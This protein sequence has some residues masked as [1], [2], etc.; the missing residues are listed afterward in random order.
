MESFWF[1]YG[2]NYCNSQDDLCRIIGKFGKIVLLFF[3]LHEAH[4]LNLQGDTIPCQAQFGERVGGGFQGAVNVGSGLAY[5]GYWRGGWR[6]TRGLGAGC[7][8]PRNGWGN[9]LCQGHIT[10]GWGYRDPVQGEMK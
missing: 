5:W 3:S 1:R 2:T 6:R 9:S 4:G 10:P 7:L 8:P